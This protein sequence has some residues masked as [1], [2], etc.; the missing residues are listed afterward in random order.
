[1]DET[2]AVAAQSRCRTFVDSGRDCSGRQA[3]IS[4]TNRVPTAGKRGHIDSARES[5]AVQRTLRHCCAANHL[6][7]VVNRHQRSTPSAVIAIVPVQR[8]KLVHPE[9]VCIW[10]QETSQPRCI[11]LLP[12]ADPHVDPHSP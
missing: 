2:N 3:L 10:V 6:V 8:V 4:S 1:M 5:T 9:R 11:V 12:L 7:V